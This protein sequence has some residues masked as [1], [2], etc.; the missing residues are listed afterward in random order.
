MHPR[1]CYNRLILSGRTCS[2]SPNASSPASTS[3]TAVSSRASSFLHL[4][5]AGDP[6]ELAGFY[7]EQGADELVFLD[8]TASSERAR[9]GLRHG[10][11]H[12]RQ[13]LHPLHRRRRHPQRR[14]RAP[15]P[16][17][18]RRQGVPQHRRRRRP[19]A[20]PRARKRFGSQC[21]VVAIDAKGMA[22]AAGRSTPTAAARPTGLDA[23][24][25]AQARS[26]TSAPARSS[27]PA[28][29]PTATW[30]ATTSP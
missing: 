23:V 17:V 29:T 22:T 18:R 12:R 25:W 11:A 4:R 3:T 19:A 10:R 21:I 6:V 27:S 7:S 2:C 28:W 20:R 15:S 30:T 13:G 5:D 24:E 9:D 8:I 16:G 1:S 26:S 14:G